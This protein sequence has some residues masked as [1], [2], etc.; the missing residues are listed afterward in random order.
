MAALVENSMTARKEVICM[1]NTFRQETVTLS[2]ALAAVGYRV[3]EDTIPGTDM[4]DVPYRYGR[5]LYP[6][7][8]YE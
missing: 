4:N 2:F 7:C 8:I 1:M 5:I 6:Y 3:H